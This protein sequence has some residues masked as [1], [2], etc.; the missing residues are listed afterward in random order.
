MIPEGQR[1]RGRCKP[2]AGQVAETQLA[3]P[4]TRPLEEVA[5][6]WRANSN[7]EVVSANEVCRPV[8]CKLWP[9]PSNVP[10]LGRAASAARATEANQALL[11]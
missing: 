6:T 9:T 8:R 7:W 2:D 11:Q 10:Q 5:A 1:P 4:K 3:M